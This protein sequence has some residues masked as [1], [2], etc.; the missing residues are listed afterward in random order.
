MVSISKEKQCIS[1]LLYYGECDYETG[2]VGEAD[3]AF[4]D[5]EAIAHPPATL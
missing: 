5:T 1:G 2:I 3:M 4:A